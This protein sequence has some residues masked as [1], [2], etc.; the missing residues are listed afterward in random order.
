MK[1]LKEEVDINDGWNLDEED[2]EYGV[3]GDIE[4]LAY[5]IRNC[6]RGSYSGAH[7]Y[8]E[9]GH[10]IKKL[11]EDLDNFGDELIHRKEEE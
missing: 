1:L 5:E 10:Y 11:A 6:V 7:T 4:S 9:L 3:I 2:L 8:R